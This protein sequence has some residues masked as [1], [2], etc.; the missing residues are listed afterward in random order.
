MATTKLS[1]TIGT[2]TSGTKF[3]V[4]A[5]VKGSM[6]EGRI[7]TSIN[8]NSSQT[9]VELQNSGAFR[10]ANYVGSYNMQL[11][12]TRLFR[13]PS[14]WY[15]FVIA[16]D[17][18][19]VTDTNRVKLY[20]NGVQETSFST[21][22]YPS[23][24]LVLKYGVSGQTFNVG[25]KDTDTYWN[26]LMTHVHF[27]DGLQYAAS[28][29]GETD[30]TSGIWTAKTTPSVTYGNNGFFLKMENASAMGTDSSGNSNTFTVSGSLTKN[31]DTPANNFATL[32]PLNAFYTNSTFSNGNTTFA[33][34][35]SSSGTVGNFL[36]NTGKYYWE[37]K[38]VSKA[39]GGDNYG[40]GIQG[41]DATATN[42]FPGDQ[43]TG[44]MFYGGGNYYNS[45]S[46]TSA[47]V[48]YT[49]GDIIGVALDCTNNKLYFSK[50][51]T[52]ILSGNPSTGANGISITDPASVTL[53]G[54]YPSQTFWENSTS[55]T[56]SI[57]FGNGYFGTTAVSSAG[58]NASS[59]GIFEYDVPANFTALS[60]KGL[61]S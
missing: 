9:W 24:N 41:Q 2:P 25:A 52:F 43:S 12:T 36:I 61:N 50:N 49:A 26:G 46:G 21:T 40:I 3:T 33:S 19:Q 14:A 27:I 60:T 16:F 45:G 13:D 51:G 47:G 53:G 8:G 59:N 1:R 44:W 35:N 7:L 5:W 34:G 42:Q 10:I 39:G 18:T 57:N 4:S 15:N 11:I 22:T 23:Q 32:N 20:V 37:V 38:A 17:T 48:T 6:A 58:T 30:S 54:Y 28:D 31:Q 56:F 55:G 29:F